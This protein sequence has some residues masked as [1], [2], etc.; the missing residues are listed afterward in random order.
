M[1]DQDLKSPLEFDSSSKIRLGTGE[2]LQTI[3]IARG[4]KRSSH[5][6][7]GTQTVIASVQ[8]LS[9]QKKPLKIQQTAPNNIR[10]NI[11]SVHPTTL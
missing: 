1:N 9:A 6:V 2:K 10:R 5:V 11:P 4:D 3:S 7:S 8:Q